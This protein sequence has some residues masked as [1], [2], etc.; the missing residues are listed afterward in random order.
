MSDEPAERS[1][2]MKGGGQG[3]R[4]GAGGWIDEGSSIM[5][6]GRVYLCGQDLRGRVRRHQ[7]SCVHTTRVKTRE[8]VQT[9]VFLLGVFEQEAV[10][11]PTFM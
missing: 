2:L 1:P 6:K 5:Q 7:R 10:R 8:L 3:G 11:N 4:R 9:G